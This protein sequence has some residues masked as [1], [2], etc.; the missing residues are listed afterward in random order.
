MAKLPDDELVVVLY[1]VLMEY[2]TGQSV[3]EARFGDR[4]VTYRNMDH[5]TLLKLYKRVWARC[6]AEVQAE[7]P[8]NDF[9]GPQRGA[10]ARFTYE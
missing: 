4:Y 7:Y 10:A 9:D 8:L 1:D 5:G 6:S 2:A 3:N